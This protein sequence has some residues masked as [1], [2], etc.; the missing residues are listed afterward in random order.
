MRDSKL[1]FLLCMFVGVTYGQ[2]FTEFI[3]VVADDRDIQDRFG[4]SVDISGNYAIIGSWGDD[5]GVADP[6]MGSA[7]IFEKSGIADWTFV[8]KITSSDRDDY[9]R[10]GWTV[11][12]DGNYAVIG[13][14]AEDDDLLDADPQLSA[15]SAYIFERAV[16]GTWNQVQKI[17]AS[18]R[19]A[20]DEF[21]YAVD[22][23]GNTIVIGSHFDNE[24]EVGLDYM[25]HTGS[26]YIFDRMVDGTWTQ[27]QKIV[28]SD[29]APDIDFPDGGGAEDVS[30]QFGCA[31]S[32]SADRMVIGAF[33]HDYNAVGGSPVAQAGAAYIFERIGG[34]WV[35]VQKLQNSDRATEDRFGWSVAI[36]GD[37]AV[38]SAYTEDQNEAGGATMANAGSAYI[39][40]RD[41]AGEWTQSQKIVPSDRSVGD[42][43]GY[44]VAIDGDF[45]II[46]SIRTNTDALGGSPLSDAGAAYS[47]Y[48]DPT[49]DTWGEFNKMD[50]SDRQIDDQLGVSVAISGSSVVLGAFQQNFNVSGLINIDD[51]GAAYFYSQEECFPTSSSQT[52]T[53]CAGQSVIVG[54]FTHSETGIYEDILFSI[55]GCDSTVTTDLTIIP[56]PSS[57]QSVSICFGYAYE[58]GGSAHTTSGVY[59][60]TIVS[61]L[62]C[63]SIVTTTL[64]VSPEN[65]VTNPVTICWGESYTIG[66]ST[67]TSAGIYT[68]VLTSW[69]LCDCT[70]TTIL[71]VQLPVDKSISQDFSL[72]TAGAEDAS[73]QWIKCDPFELIAGAT[74]QTYLAPTIGKYAV[75]VTEDFCSDTSSCIYVDIL[76]T[77]ENKKTSLHVYPNPSEG[78][79]TVVMP[80]FGLEDY[81]LIITN[82]LGKIVARFNPSTQ[83]YSISTDN[84]AP[85]LYVLTAIKGHHLETVSLIVR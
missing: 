35:E 67:Y 59:T 74:E 53:L 22:I 38:V 12:I 14:Y 6:N 64:T 26:A 27:S 65:A 21:G 9:D 66:A 72:L 25:Y 55:D 10:F 17:I 47:F 83:N 70:I 40:K 44:D 5:F 49:L 13:A 45:M 7:Y 79:I 54:P 76:S 73:Y 31:V 29:R 75:I 33:H 46:G 34:I 15:G 32:I 23:S 82:S 60:D 80:E 58:I 39:F 2:T 84:L 41:V 4:W 56:A 51:A 28:G 30:D 43:F 81:E 3:K 8:Q 18:D 20:G 42:R 61:G 63:D 16:D 36:D 57:S 1:L 69:A 19:T 62:G 68:D 50:A 71:N 52:L 11:A 24:N 48:L 78:L 77:G 37:Y 85:G